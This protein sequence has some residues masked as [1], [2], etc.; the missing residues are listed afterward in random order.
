MPHPRLL[1]VS[2][3]YS[4][5]GAPIALL[6]L[7]AGLTS[8]FDILVASPCD[9]PLRQHFLAHRIHAIV[10]PNLFHDVNV[11]A[12]LLLSYDAVLA[13]TLLSPLPIHAAY[14]IR[15]PSFWYL[16]EGHAA[17]YLCQRFP[18]ISS[19]FPLATCIVVPCKF[20][21]NLYQNVCHFSHIIPYGIEHRDAPFKPRSGPLKALQLG[22]I[23]ARK[24]QDIAIAALRSLRERP[25]ELHI[26]GN[27]HEPTYDRQLRNVSADLRNIHF[28]PGIDLADTP[29]L[30]AQCDVLIVPSRDEVTPM[31]ILEA[32]AAGKPVIASNVGGIPEMIAD[33][34]T[35]FLFQ[36]EN[37]PQLAA[38]LA[39]L[40]DNAAISQTIG[41]NARQFVRRERTLELYHQTFASLLYQL[42]PVC[43]TELQS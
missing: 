31:V 36:T 14:Q 20:S 37:A 6:N 27:P 40:D 7:L 2:H 25:L 42:L 11:A 13:N 30:I 24:G 1:A 35:G 4:L 29:A 18:G 17:N 39:E 22:S 10:V 12:A 3:D 5:T 32:M 34:Q 15:K 23:E 16:H 26:V 19:A 33:R 9:G 21:Q 28:S 8:Q 38:I 43:K 41:E